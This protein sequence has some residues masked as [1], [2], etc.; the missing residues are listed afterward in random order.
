M[1]LLNNQHKEAL[2]MKTITEII[3]GAQG[4]LNISYKLEAVFEDYLDNGYKT[5]LHILRVMEAAVPLFMRRYAGTGRKPYPYQPFIRS[6][7]AK[8]FFKIDTTKEL[9]QRLR[10]D[11]NLR[12][13]CGFEQ[14]PGESTF[15]RN[16]TELSETAVMRETLDKPVKEAHEGKVVCHVSRDSAATEARERV[17]KEAKEEGKGEKK[18]RGRPKKGEKR[19][20]KEESVLERQ[21][22]ESAEAA[23]EKTDRACAHG[24]KKNSRGNTQF[25]TGYK[26]HLDV[27]D[28]GFPL[29]AFV[30][31]GNAHDSQVAIPLE[32]MREG[33]VFFVTV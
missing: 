16:F 31:G 13:L 10:I 17:E 11:S 22:H 23:L 24:C 6:M 9:I 12:V 29:S 3:G 14:V 33:K 27:G 5:F 28:C 32:K 2:V 30:S 19:P 21:E 26:L 18:R 1:E 15:S 20:P 7:W 4:L 25:R 8:S